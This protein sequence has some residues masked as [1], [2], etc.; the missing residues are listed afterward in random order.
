MS[1]EDRKLVTRYHRLNAARQILE[2]IEEPANTVYYMFTGVHMPLEDS[3]V[4]DVSD[5]LKT[6]STDAYRNMIQ[7]KRVRPADA[8]LL[9]RNIP[10]VSN[11]VYAMYDDEDADLLDRDYYAMVNAGSYS[12]VFKVLDNNGAKPSTSAPDFSHI[13]GANTHMYVTSD[14]YAWKYL[15][16]ITAGMKA[17][18]ASSDL[19]PVTANAENAAISVDGA[20]DVIKVENVGRGYDNYLTGTFSAADVRVDGDPNLY[21]V[22][23]SVASAVNGFYTDCAIYL[24]SG[25]G[26]GEYRTVTNYFTNINGKFIELDEPFTA[27]PTNGTTWQIY[28]R[29]QINGSGAETEQAYARALINATSSNSVYRIEVIEPGAG[30]DYFTASVVANAT[31][32]VI[33]DAVLRP[34]YSPPGG[35]GSDPADELAAHHICFSTK[36]SNSESNTLTTTNDFKQIGVIQDP[37]F[38]NVSFNFS[39]LSGSFI[40]G[41]KTFKINPGRVATNVSVNTTSS[42]VTCNA[43]DF[44]TQL[45]VGQWIWLTTDSNDNNQIAVVNNIVNSSALYL[46]ANAYFANTETTLYDARANNQLATCYVANTIDTNTVNFSNVAGMFGTG[47]KLVGCMSGAYGVIDTVERSGIEKGFETFI[48][49]NRYVGQ[50]VSGTFLE[51]EIVFQSNLA[52]ANASLHSTVVNGSDIVLL[53][54]N[55]AGSFDITNV[56]NTIVGN[57]SAAIAQLDAKYSPELV[58]GSGDVL[59]LENIEPVTRTNT[60]NETIKIIFEF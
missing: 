20:I 12:H 50:V 40:T 2:S 38:A 52:H 48:Q 59:F 44:E 15:Y 3:G 51:N 26:A 1:I 13:V 49:L 8:A 5:T 33:I 30:Y 18:F 24:A 43:A 11:T 39:T 27:T 55:Q 56:A 36:F 41:E 47:D 17:Q 7:G 25:A 46:T 21:A 53:T 57:T 6:I 14:G 23:N 54:S 45:Q 34:I 29:V 28:P 31:V 37:L 9:V 4:P 10:Y 32:G 22:V 16:S 19:F 58:H 35:H 42:L 60:Q